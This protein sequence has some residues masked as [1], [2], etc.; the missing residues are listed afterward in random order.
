MLKLRKHDF[1]KNNNKFIETNILTNNWK[2]QKS[3]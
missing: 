1:Y 2:Y 3:V